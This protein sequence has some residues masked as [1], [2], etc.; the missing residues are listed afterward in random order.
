[1]QLVWFHHCQ[2]VALAF[3]LHSTIMY[4]FNSFLD[5]ITFPLF[6]PAPSSAPG[7]VVLEAVDSRT[8]YISWIA[9]PQND[10][11][12]IIRSYYIS[13]IELETGWSLSVTSATTSV[14]IPSLHP[15]YTYLCAVAAV[16]VNEGPYSVN[17][18]LRLPEDGKEHSTISFYLT[19]NLPCHNHVYFST[20]SSYQLR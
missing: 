7:A 14:T 19:Q 5:L 8:L 1:M 13:A 9:P 3:L 20:H 12:G 18:S 17:T 10:H 11:N 4:K 15:Y 16:T 2:Y 6:H